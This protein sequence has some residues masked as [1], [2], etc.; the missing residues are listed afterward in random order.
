MKKK[1][2]CGRKCTFWHFSL[3]LSIGLGPVCKKYMLPILA[4][5]E[6]CFSAREKEKAREKS[7]IQIQPKAWPGASR[8]WGPITKKIAQ[9]EESYGN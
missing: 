5:Q 8:G 9:E 2:K 6:L 3:R 7:V 1:V 4:A